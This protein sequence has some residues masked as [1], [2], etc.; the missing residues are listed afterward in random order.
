MKGVY[1]TCVY[2]CVIEMYMV[3]VM[4]MCVMC[5]CVLCIVCVYSRGWAQVYMLHHLETGSFL[6]YL[7]LRLRQAVQ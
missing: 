7:P 6:C 2:T 3:C 5:M 1:V 4:D